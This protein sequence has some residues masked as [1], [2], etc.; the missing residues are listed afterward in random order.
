MCTDQHLNLLLCLQSVSALDVPPPVTR[1]LG[2]VVSDLH[3]RSGHHD[4]R[5]LPGGGPVVEVIQATCVAH[6]VQEDV[7][8]LGVEVL[9]HVVDGELLAKVAAKVAAEAAHLAVH[10]LGEPE[11]HVVA[12]GVALGA[13]AVVAVRVVHGAAAGRVALGDA[14]D[15]GRVGV[16]GQVRRV[17][18]E[19]RRVVGRPAEMDTSTDV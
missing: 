17:A 15:V 10:A 12:A 5:R 18:L 6:L 1:H 7:D 16:Q 19:Q 13:A 14:V 3:R 4:E 8:V 2:I 9:E 11:R